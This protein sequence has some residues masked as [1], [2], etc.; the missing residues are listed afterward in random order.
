MSNLVESLRRALDGRN[1]VAF[2]YLFGSRNS[3]GDHPRADLDVALFIH[4]SPEPW[5]VLDFTNLI[6]SAL[7]RD[8]VDVVIL[9]DAPPAL[10][11][12]A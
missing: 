5:P 10:A 9:N 3:G 2:A 12:E 7:H 8:D 4:A 11:F 1:D 6:A